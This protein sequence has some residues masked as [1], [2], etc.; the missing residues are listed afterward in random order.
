MAQSSTRRG[1]DFY[2]LAAFFALFV[3]F[4]VIA[5]AVGSSF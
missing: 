3:L 5:F 2:I 1:V 4:L